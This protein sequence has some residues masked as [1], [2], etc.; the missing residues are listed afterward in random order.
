[1]TNNKKHLSFYKIQLPSTHYYILKI[2]H[3]FF[4]VNIIKKYKD[5]RVK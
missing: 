1:M 4:I 2:L 3:N 5:K